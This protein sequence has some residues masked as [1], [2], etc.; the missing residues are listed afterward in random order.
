MTEQAHHNAEYKNINQG[1]SSSSQHGLNESDS[2][3]L[4]E[5]YEPV[6]TIESNEKAQKLYVNNESASRAQNNHND[7]KE[8]QEVYVNQ[9]LTEEVYE[10]A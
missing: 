9:G 4:Q 10:N 1:A 7:N 5:I 8:N 3:N 2:D 6:N